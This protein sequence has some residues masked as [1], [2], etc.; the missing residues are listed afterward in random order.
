MFEFVQYVNSIT[1]TIHVEPY[2]MEGVSFFAGVPPLPLKGVN[3]IMAWRDQAKTKL[4]NC[5]TGGGAFVSNRNLNGFV[6]V[7]VASCSPAAAYMQMLDISGIGF[8]IRAV[9]SNSLSG[10]SFVASPSVRVIYTPRWVRERFMTND[11]ITMSCKHL[12]IS[13]GARK[14]INV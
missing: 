5:L 4:F 14:T 8:P 12:V 3:R 10:S 9:D 13:G 1:G 6:S 2:S 7:D 11:V